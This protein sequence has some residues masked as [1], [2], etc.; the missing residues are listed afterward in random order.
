[1]EVIN[2]FL[3]N[4][5]AVKP[6]SLEREYAK[7]H[8]ITP[9]DIKVFRDWL[10]TQPHLPGD[11]ITDV[12]LILAYHCCERSLPAAKKVLDLNYTL[13]T[14]YAHFKERVIDK[15]LEKILNIVLIAALPEPSVDGYSVFY[16]RFLAPDPKNFFFNDTVK[17]FMMVYDLWLWEKGSC[18]GVI[19]II[20]MDGVQIGHLTRLDLIGM[21]NLL[22]FVQECMIVKLKEV[23]FLNAPYFMDKL[24]MFMKPFLKKTLLDI[25]RI[26]V[27][28]DSSVHRV[29]PK[30]AFP[31][32]LG[33]DYLEYGRIRDELIDRMR[34]NE[35]FFREE[36]KK[37]VQESLR[38]S[39]RDG[40]S[41]HGV[42]G[43]FKKLE[44]D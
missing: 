2:Y 23:Y 32:E 17:A 39:G 25:I 19:I 12:D 26:C 18:P 21:K 36:M 37:R 13:K 41:N 7:N 38:P 34:A 6:I 28:D 24:M 29:I 4:K 10:M 3:Y 31:K 43:S 16:L 22:Y 27:A 9:Q 15:K 40:A 14:N 30:R 11:L 5:M 8:E 42:Q 35:D 20:D 33:G 44:I 1:M